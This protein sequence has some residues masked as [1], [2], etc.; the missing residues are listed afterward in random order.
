MTVSSTPL[1]TAAL[2]CNGSV[3][4]FPFSFGVGGAIDI[5]VVLTDS[6]GNETVLTQGEDYTVVGAIATDWDI[7]LNPIAWDWSTGGT[8]TTIETYAS[9]YTI[10]IETDIPITQETR[11][12]ENMPTLYK[13]FEAGLDKLT[14]ILLQQNV[15]IIALQIGQSTGEPVTPSSLTYLG[16]LVSDPDTSGWGATQAGYT[17]HTVVD[18]GTYRLRYWNGAETLQC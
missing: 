9:G 18:D 6:D 14:R 17:W 10:T 16:K 3:Q 4:D 1:K 8:V 7:S 11:F 12:T 5:K 13:T 15:Q 2:N